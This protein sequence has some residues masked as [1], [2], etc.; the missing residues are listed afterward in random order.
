MNF[1][2]SLV[3]KSIIF[4][5]YFVSGIYLPSRDE[6]F[7]WSNSGVWQICRYVFRPA[8]AVVPTAVNVTTTPRPVDVTGM[9]GEYYTSEYRS[10]ALTAT[11][12]L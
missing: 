6:Y 8:P 3:L 10:M 5:Y 11:F 7:M 1:V 12:T 9:T 4:V 2:I